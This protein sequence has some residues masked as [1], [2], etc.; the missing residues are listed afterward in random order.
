MHCFLR[1]SYAPRFAITAFSSAALICP[2]LSLSKS[3]KAS[4][5]S[6]SLVPL[7]VLLDI[8]FKNSGKSMDP[9]L[10]AS[11]SLIMLNSSDSVGFWP[12]EFMTTPSSSV[13]IVPSPS[14]MQSKHQVQINAAT[15][16]AD[17]C[18]TGRRHLSGLRG[19]R[20]FLSGKR[21]LGSVRAICSGFS[22]KFI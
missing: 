8:M 17:L 9:V 3:L 21:G 13:V 5:K 15:T 4:L 19:V 7:G 1:E 2:L 20:G 10:S 18:R 22:R 12:S 6:S 11:T 14:G 16:N